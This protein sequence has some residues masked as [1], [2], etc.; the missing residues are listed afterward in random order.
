MSLGGIA[1]ALGLAIDAEVIALDACHRGLAL[2]GP[3][4]SLEE[5]RAVLLKASKTFAPA[6]L[7]S[8]FITA[9]TFLPVLAFSGEMGRLFRPMVLT[10]SVV[11]LAAALATLTVG[12]AVRGRLLVRPVAPEL[13]H[14]VMRGLVRVYRPFVH[15]ALSWPMLTLFTAGL[16]VASSVP[17]L[18]RLGGEFLP[19]ISEGDLLFM[20]TTLRGAD[21]D[22]SVADLRRQNRTIGSFPEVASVFG[23]VGRAD[24]ATDPAPFSMG[25]STIRLRPKGDWPLVPRVRWYSG[26]A[27]GPLRRLLGLIWPEASTETTGELVEKLDRAT[28]LPGWSNGWTAPARARMDM[29]STGIRTP[30]GIRIVA[31]DPARRE[32]LGDELR[33]LALSLPGT[34][35]ATLESLGQE[36]ELEFEAD[37]AALSRFGVER[38]V[39]QAAADSYISGGQVGDIER[40]GH[41]LRLRVVPEVGLRGR[42]DQLRELTVRGS[43]SAAPVP[44]ALLGHPRYAS[45]A[46][47]LRTERGEPVGYVL[48]DLAE[49]TDPRRY[50]ADA[51]GALDRSERAGRISL[52]P[53]ERI[54]WAGQFGLLAAGE[55][56]LAW[57]APAIFVSMMLLL[58]SLFGSL[59]EALIVLAA[60]PFALVGSIWMLYL[61]G[62]P[63]SAPV[64]AGLLLVV[65]LAMQ[66]AVVMVVYIDAAFHRR[67]REGR[68][69]TREDIVAAHAEG[70]VERLRPKVMTVVTMTA[71]LLPLLWSDGAGADVMRRIAA[72]MI[73]GLCTSAILTLEVLPVLYTIWRVRQLRRA[74]R[75]GVPIAELVGRGPSWAR[76]VTSPPGV[77]AP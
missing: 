72:P 32:L 6:I 47:A 49:G 26:W 75:L 19:P 68:L 58:T 51:K 11:V 76:G 3:E 38:Q 9:L 71:S 4:A 18:S 60:V 59:T 55:R 15:A 56:R 62:Y 46:G 31:S 34:R 23:K 66:T 17:L 22:D 40:D 36:V 57:I 1:I 48:V 44:L 43:A 63:L 69:R 73:G 39:A 12:P 29:M 20:P 13:E 74:D 28:R 67:V 65:G 7:T 2:L 41:R 50:V 21:V 42:A 53:G 70:S 64:W 35:N 77:T 61:L 25:E 5:R 52:R 54:E 33:A 45:R 27:P 30:V 8:L 24:S 37:G 16:A 10:K 14:R